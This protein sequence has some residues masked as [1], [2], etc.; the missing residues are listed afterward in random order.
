M[1]KEELHKEKENL[2]KHIKELQSKNSSEYEDIWMIEHLEEQVR[3]IDKE[4]KYL[5]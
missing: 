3:R 1:D 2:E 4:I 5:Y